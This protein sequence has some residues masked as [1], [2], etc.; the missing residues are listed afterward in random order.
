MEVPK[1]YGHYP[2]THLKGRLKAAD[3]KRKEAHRQLR[4]M[5]VHPWCGQPS[6]TRLATGLLPQRM[7]KHGEICRPRSR[8]A[9]NH[10]PIVLSA[11]RTAETPRGL[12]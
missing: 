1:D 9:V 10:M 12:T 8:A 5:H 7:H 4:K 2:P 6:P 11:G 3:V